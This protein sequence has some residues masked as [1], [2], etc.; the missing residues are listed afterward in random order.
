[1][2]LLNFCFVSTNGP[3]SQCEMRIVP[4]FASSSKWRDFVSF[5][6]GYLLYTFIGCLLFLRLLQ[7]KKLLNLEVCE[8]DLVRHFRVYLIKCR[9]T[10][11]KVTFLSGQSRK[12]KNN[13]D[14]RSE[15]IKIQCA[16]RGKSF[17]WLDEKL[18]RVFLS[19]SRGVVGAKPI[20]FRHW[21]GNRPIH[22]N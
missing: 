14:K 16:K 19:Q 10:K 18:A 1:M 11:T 7:I 17:I 8:N 9:K 22:L 6:I 2:Q 13:T 20:S 4:D 15:P 12:R 5:Y 3:W 21:N